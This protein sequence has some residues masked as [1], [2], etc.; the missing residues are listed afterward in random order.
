MRYFALVLQDREKKKIIPTLLCTIGMEWKGNPGGF[1][2]WVGLELG[3]EEFGVYLDQPYQHF[4]IF[5]I[6][7]HID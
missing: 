3:Q 1:L 7:S 5:T 6:R 2:G 4:Y